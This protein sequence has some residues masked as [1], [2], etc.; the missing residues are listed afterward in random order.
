MKGLELKEWRKNHGFTQE[1]L[2]FQ[3]GLKSRQTLNSREKSNEDL[4]RLWELA[5]VALEKAPSCQMTNP[6]KRREIKKWNQEF[7]PTEEEVR[8]FQ[9]GGG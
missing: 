8:K 3:L 9:N 6:M 4:P 1:E 2:M 7:L 5:L